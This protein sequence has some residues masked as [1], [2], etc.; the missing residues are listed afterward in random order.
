MAMQPDY[1]KNGETGVSRACCGPVR[2]AASDGRV[3][4]LLLVLKAEIRLC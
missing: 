3:R 2:T 4:F 1:K